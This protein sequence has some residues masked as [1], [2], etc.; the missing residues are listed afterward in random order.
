MI[1][2]GAK[3]SSLPGRAFDP[4]RLCLL[5]LSVFAASLLFTNSFRIFAFSA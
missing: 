4:H 3:P 1:V 2:Q 5:A